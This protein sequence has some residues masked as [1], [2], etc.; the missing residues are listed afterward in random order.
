MA[1]TIFACLG[2]LTA[3][4]VAL[5]LFFLYSSEWVRSWRLRRD[6]EDLCAVLAYCVDDPDMK[7]FLENSTR[8][9]GRSRRVP[10]SELR[11]QIQQIWDDSPISL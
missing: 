11:K 1:E 5:A 2:A 10:L 8:A 9:L 6:A 3:L 7:D 4:L